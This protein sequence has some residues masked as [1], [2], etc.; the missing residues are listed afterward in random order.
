MAIFQ[1]K[2]AF[3]PLKL[4]WRHVLHPQLASYMNYRQSTIDQPGSVESRAS[5]DEGDVITA[6][7]T[8]DR[9]A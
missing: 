7:D 1:A 8:A 5:R 3:Y 2:H 9:V 6:R 4:L